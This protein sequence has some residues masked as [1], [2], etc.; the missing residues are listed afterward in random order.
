MAVF[1]HGCS[2]ILETVTISNDK[3]EISKVYGQEKFEINVKNLTFKNALIANNDP[4]HRRVMLTGIRDKANVFNEADFFES[5]A[6]PSP[7]LSDY[8]LGVGDVLSFKQL[9]E[10]A[11]VETEFPSQKVETDYLLGVGDELTLIQLSEEINIKLDASNDVL[12]SQPV[13][14]VLLTSGLVGTN[15][16]ILFLGLGSVKAENRSLDEMQTEARNI[17]IRKGLAPNFQLE[18]SGFNSKKAFVTLNTL[19]QSGTAYEKII[20]ITNL[21]I[22]LKELILLYGLQLS[23]RETLIV[24]LV[25]D[26]KEYRTTAGQIFENSLRDLIIEDRDQIEIFEA[27]SNTDFREVVVGSNGNILLPNIGSL[28]AKNRSLL[29]IQAEISNILEKKGMIPSFQLEITD[30]KSKRFFIVS[31]ELGS[32]II[33]LT[34]STLNLKEAIMRSGLSN[35]FDHGQT[36]VTLGRDN[37]TY[38]ITLQDA[39]NELGSKIL[40][41][42]GDNVKFKNFEYKPGQ[43]FALSGAGNAT[44]IAIDPSKRET[45]ADILFTPNGALN[46]L[47]AKRS[48]I[49]LLRGRNPSTAYHLDAQNVSRIL[50]A[51]K[52]ELRPNDIV[53]VAERPIISFTRTLSE[54]LPLRILLRDIQNNDIP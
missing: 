42:D 23:E 18:I 54:I 41:Q 11:K 51:A 47:L 14:N 37:E 30:F 31:E 35:I 22:T 2:Q 27:E 26:G 28:K 39:I 46:N 7:P 9:N 24:T 40:I 1:L 20:P 25:R 12:N 8:L 6:P 53:Y 34:S 5:T 19:Y 45:L 10:F 43:V 15:G 13:E 33:P 16:N 32:Q 52:T 50:V 17:L 48:E 3:Q 4:Y 29:E 44:M 38:Q 21:P 36:I 49:Y